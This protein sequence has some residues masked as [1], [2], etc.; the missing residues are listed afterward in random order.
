MNHEQFLAFVMRLLGARPHMLARENLGNL[1]RSKGYTIYLQWDWIAKRCPG[2]LD[3]VDGE[4]IDMTF[5]ND[6]GVGFEVPKDRRI[7]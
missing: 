3:I 7:K 4:R 6:D 1:I 5:C 2:D